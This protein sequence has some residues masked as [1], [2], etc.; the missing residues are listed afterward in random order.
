MSKMRSRLLLRLVLL[1][2]PDQTFG[3]RRLAVVLHRQPM[4][5]NLSVKTDRHRQAFGRAWRPVTFV[6]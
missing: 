1:E 3:L 2:M 6:R 4:R 5:P